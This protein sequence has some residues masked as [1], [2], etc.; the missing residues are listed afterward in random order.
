MLSITETV[1]LGLGSGL[2]LFMFIPC[3]AYCFSLYDVTLFCRNEEPL[4]G[5][6]VI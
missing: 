4:H 2:L 6:V 5:Q 3:C 1:L